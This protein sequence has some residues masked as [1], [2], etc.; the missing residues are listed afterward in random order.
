MNVGDAMRIMMVM[1]MTIKM[2]EKVHMEWIQIGMSTWVLWIISP[3]NYTTFVFVMIIEDV[4]KCT[5]QVNVQTRNGHNLY[6]RI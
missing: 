6:N 1:I 5:I 2:T 4:I 3:V